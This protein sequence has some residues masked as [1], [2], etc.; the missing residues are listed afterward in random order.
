MKKYFLNK[1]T[2]CLHFK[3]YCR[4]SKYLPSDIEWFDTENE[5]Y[6]YAARHLRICK[7]C[8]KKKEQNNDKG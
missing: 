6:Q 4:E 1:K 2:G 7:S 5:A 3:G 8:E